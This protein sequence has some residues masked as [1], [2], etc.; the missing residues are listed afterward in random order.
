MEMPSSMFWALYEVFEELDIGHLSFY[1]DKSERESVANCFRSAIG[2]CTITQKPKGFDVA[3]SALTYD[4]YDEDFGFTSIRVAPIDHALHAVEVNFPNIRYQGVTCYAFRTLQGG[5]MGWTE[6][7]HG[8][9]DH[10]VYEPIGEA[11]AG[12][13]ERD[14]RGDKRALTMLGALLA[15][16]KGAQ[17]EAMG[18]TVSHLGSSKPYPTAWPGPSW[19]VRGQSTVEFAVV[20][21][22]FMSLTVALATLWHALD[23]GLILN[24]VLAV[25]SHHI[26]AVAPVTITDIFLY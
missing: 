26:Q 5:D 22:G 11:L 4:D 1:C 17:P 7:S 19:Q 3:F 15:P 14:C 24:H 20:M 21:A 25:A 10:D 6:Y 13:L 9:S 18:Q 8:V 16:R 12:A 2:E 23:S